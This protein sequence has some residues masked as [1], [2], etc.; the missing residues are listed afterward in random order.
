MSWPVLHVAVH[1][2]LSSNPPEFDICC[3]GRTESRLARRAVQRKEGIA[4]QVMEREERKR[5]EEKKQEWWQ[6]C[7]LLMNL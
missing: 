4:L 5:K 2:M 1:H 6:T 7:R 3:E